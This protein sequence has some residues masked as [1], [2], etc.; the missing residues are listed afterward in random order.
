VFCRALRTAAMFPDPIRSGSEAGVG[1]E[2][3][4]MRIL[5]AELAKQGGSAV[6]E[7]LGSYKRTACLCAVMIAAGTAA[8]IYAH[9]KGG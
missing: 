7:A 4:K 1:R 5:L 8:G 6:R 3:I 2:V 9:L